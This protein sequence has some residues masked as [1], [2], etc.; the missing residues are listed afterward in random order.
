[1]GDPDQARPGVVTSAHDRGAL[2]LPDDDCGRAVRRHPS[3]PAACVD[4]RAAGTDHV[5][6]RPPG[7]GL[8][9]PAGAA[10]AP[11]WLHGID[12]R[13]H[14]AP[15][16]RV[17]VVAGAARGSAPRCR[18]ARRPSDPV[19]ARMTEL[20]TPARPVRVRLDADGV[21]THLESAAGWQPVTRV[22]NRWRTDCDWW[23]NPVSR[24]YW[25]L[26][27]CDDPAPGGARS[28]TPPGCGGRR[29]SYL[30]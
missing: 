7:S 19:E 18:A 17:R 5:A 9:P 2:C 25:R 22:L 27:V 14:R 15:A 3:A 26:L 29:G 4:R 21:P 1:M 20:L 10:D 23:R 6:C 8:Y 30:A 12:R 24:E 13:C 28:P 11:R 16:G